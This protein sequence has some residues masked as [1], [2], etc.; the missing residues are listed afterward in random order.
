MSWRIKV[1]RNYLW[2]H[3]IFIKLPWTLKIYQIFIPQGWLWGTWTETH[4]QRQLRSAAF[5]TVYIC[6]FEYLATRE[7]TRNLLIPW[8]CRPNTNNKYLVLETLFSTWSKV[9]KQS[10]QNI[11]IELDDTH[12]NKGINTNSGLVRIYFL[13]ADCW[14]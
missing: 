4:L 5:W 11:P 1:F 13:N 2:H 8:N 7:T 6:I 10:S 12:Q 14:L 3:K 9:E